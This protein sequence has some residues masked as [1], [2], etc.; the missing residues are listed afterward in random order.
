MDSCH[1]LLGTIRLNHII[2][3]TILQGTKLFGFISKGCDHY[4]GCIPAAANPGKYLR[5]RKPGQHDVKKHEIRVPICVK[6]NRLHAIFCDFNVK[7]VTPQIGLQY[8]GAINVVL[9]N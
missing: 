4:Y 6:I 9:D 3:S 7:A 8:R 2:I 1:D 5:T